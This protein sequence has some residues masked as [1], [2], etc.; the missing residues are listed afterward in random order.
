LQKIYHL[1]K[2]KKNKY[3]SKTA[4]TSLF[5]NMDASCLI[6]TI[7][8]GVDICPCFFKRSEKLNEE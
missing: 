7:S 8:F 3:I 6:Q 2:P 5:E 4:N 1:A